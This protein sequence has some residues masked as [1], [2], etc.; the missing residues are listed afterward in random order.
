MATATHQ[1]TAHVRTTVTEE[2]FFVKAK[3]ENRIKT[4]MMEPE[5]N[6]N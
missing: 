5:L 3:T 1:T 4:K 6:K 2:V